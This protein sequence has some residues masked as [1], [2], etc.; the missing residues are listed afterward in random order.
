LVIF[1]I[2]L[3]KKYFTTKS[4]KKILYLTI[5]NIQYPRF[6]KVVNMIKIHPNKDNLSPEDLFIKRSEKKKKKKSP[7]QGRNRVL[8]V[9]SF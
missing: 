8:C 7:R 2:F 3:N 5:T 1:N 6:S 4:N 9:A